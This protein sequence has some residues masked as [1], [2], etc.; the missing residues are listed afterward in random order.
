MKKKRS[1]ASDAR[2]GASKHEIATNLGYNFLYSEGSA[3][4][5]GALDRTP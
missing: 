4:I 5:L 2:Y 3:M 1:L